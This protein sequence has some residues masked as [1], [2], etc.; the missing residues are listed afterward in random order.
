MAEPNRR[1]RRRKGLWA[2]LLALLALIRREGH[3]L[4]RPLILFSLTIMV[5]VTIAPTPAPPPSPPTPAPDG[6]N[7]FPPRD[8][9]TPGGPDDWDVDTIPAIDAN[10]H[11]IQFLV[12]T[13]NDNYRW[14]MGSTEYVGIRGRDTI[15]VEDVVAKLPV[16]FALP[17]IVV[18]MAS[19]EN[20][21]EHP[22]EE[23]FR[24]QERADVLAQLAEDHFIRR[25][26]IYKVNLGAFTA[27][28]N[29]SATSAVERRVALLQVTCMDPGAD[30]TSGMRNALIEAQ[31]RHDTSID[32]GMYS[33][34][35]PNQF[36]VSVAYAGSRGNPAPPRCH[37]VRK[38]VS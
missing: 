3:S 35:S 34:F 4:L 14:L 15:P 26:T 22:P 5:F 38:S 27:R 19:H 11:A 37:H 6:P 18:G 17:L 1:N 10:G 8:S 20:A 9:V 24:A 29:S 16:D 36:S 30:M 2:L 25:P 33:N 23:N 28:V 12:G 31:R 7:V 13:L 21:L 32:G